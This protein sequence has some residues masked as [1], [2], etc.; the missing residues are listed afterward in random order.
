MILLATA[1]LGI[2]LYVILGIVGD[3]SIPLPEANDTTEVEA[4][5]QSAAL[6]SNQAELITFLQT[7]DVDSV[8]ALEKYRGWLSAFGYPD[9]PEFLQEPG[10]RPD[11]EQLATRDDA[12]LLSLAGEGDTLA[13]QILA[14]RSVG[15]DPLDAANWYRNAAMR[16]SVYAMLRLSDLMETFAN[17]KLNEFN[18]DPVFASS[19]QDLRD[20]VPS[21]PEEA[22]RW[23]IAAATVGGQPALSVDLAARLER[24]A[25]ALQDGTVAQV[26]SSSQRLVLELAAERR[27]HGGLALTTVPPEIFVSAAN[28]VG[29]AI[30]CQGLIVPF[31]DISTCAANLIRTAPQ[32]AALLWVC[33]VV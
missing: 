32:K 4:E 16:G 7:Q 25:A 8:Q 14:T 11:A 19:L 33:K 23:A 1:L 12:A 26:C 22:L 30:P 17:P 5:L 6:I 18:T 28:L 27:A 10:Y 24:Q 2:L 13:M 21:L 29:D 9:L 20:A 3:V 31:I 15:N